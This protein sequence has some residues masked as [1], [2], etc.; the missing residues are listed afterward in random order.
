M[1]P[2]S[3][4]A[5]PKRTLGVVAA[6]CLILGLTE[7][8]VGLGLLP[9]YLKIQQWLHQSRFL[10]AVNVDLFIGAGGWSLLFV[11]LLALSHLIFAVMLWKVRKNIAR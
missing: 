7:L 8:L 1:S 9:E 10:T 11:G 2:P 4:H 5:S 6:L 3:K